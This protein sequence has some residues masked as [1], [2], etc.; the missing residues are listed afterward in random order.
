MRAA[1]LNIEFEK[2]SQIDGKLEQL[3]KILELNQTWKTSQM[4]AF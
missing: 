4:M 3:N 2:A 1:E